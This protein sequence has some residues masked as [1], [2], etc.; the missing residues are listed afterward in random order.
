[1]GKNRFNVILNSGDRDAGTL[2][3]NARFQVDLTSNGLKSDELDKP[4]RMSWSMVSQFSNYMSPATQPYLMRMSCSANNNI[5]VQD[6]AITDI[7]GLVYIMTDTS[8]S[9]GICISTTD[10]GYT[11]YNSLRNVGW[12]SLN[13][14]DYNGATFNV[15]NDSATNT[16][17]PYSVVLYFEEL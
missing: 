12:F 16:A 9:K 5:V 3:Y 13:M 6:G 1:M 17:T 14:V 2:Q 4:Y 8:T 11:C 15:A 7:I 10:N